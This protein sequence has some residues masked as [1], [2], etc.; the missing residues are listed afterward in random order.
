MEMDKNDERIEIPL[1]KGKIVLLFLGA[2]AF[3]AGGVWVVINPTGFKYSPEWVVI[4][5]IIAILFF[6]LAA[7]MLFRKFFDKTMGLVIDNTGIFDNASGVSAGHI[8]WVN[9]IEI[10]KVQVVNQKFLILIVT[11]P[12]DY[13]NK[14]T[15]SFLR[16]AAEAN[17]KMYGSPIT[18]SANGLKCNF[19]ELYRM[20]QS[21]HRRSDERVERS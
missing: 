10:Q 7:I 6:G 8:P 11:N 9:I 16:R 18:I 15:N 17:H 19:D 1:S 5:G 12:E 3:V 14:Q 21:R 20:I 13:L 2:L 4:V